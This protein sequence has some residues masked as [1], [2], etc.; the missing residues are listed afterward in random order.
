MQNRYVWLS[1]DVVVDMNR[2]IV[3]NSPDGPEPFALIDRDKLEGAMQRPLAKLVYGG[4]ENVVS[5][6]VEYM[7][8]VANAHSFLQGNKRTGF[9]AGDT[10]LINNG[11]NL[12]VPDMDYVAD[13]FTSVITGN[14]S[15]DDFT[16]LLEIHIEPLEI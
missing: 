1:I 15:I 8:A 14:S 7:V 4:V 10:F 2:E 11:Y 9:A 12:T 3:A 5:L 6:S 16:T 13:F